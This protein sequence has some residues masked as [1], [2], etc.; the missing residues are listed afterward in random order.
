MVSSYIY[1]GL[2]EQ[3]R[4]RAVFKIRTKN[5]FE[6]IDAVCKALNVSKSDLLGKC[7]VRDLAIA[8]QIA[9]YLIRKYH[10]LT[11]K[12]IGKLFNKDHSTV[13]YSCEMVE[14][15]NGIDKVFTDK[16]N[17]VLKLTNY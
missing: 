14:E 1:T 13:I 12:N 8:R 4:F 9:M 5:E 10:G 11:L 15:L 6:V 16:I 17:K 2:N 3:D 7:R